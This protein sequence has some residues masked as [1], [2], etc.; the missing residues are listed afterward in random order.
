MMPW[1]HA[2]RGARRRRRALPLAPL[3]G[4][5]PLARRTTGPMGSAALPHS[6]R[7]ATTATDQRHFPAPRG[8]ARRR[9]TLRGGATT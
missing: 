1:S 6:G 3:Q 8:R 5:A 2:S 4:P 7:T 9:T